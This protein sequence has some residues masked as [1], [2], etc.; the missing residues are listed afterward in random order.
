MMQ[1]RIIRG[2]GGFYYVRDAQGAEY[3][4]RARGR[5]RKEHK[6]PLVGDEVVFTPGQ[7]EEHG[8]L[9][10]ILPRRSECL[11]PPAAN[12]SLLLV[13]C[14]P[15][16]LPDLMLVDRLIIRAKRGN[17][18]A[19]LVINKCD[20]DPTLAETLS[21]QY[22]GAGVPI[23]PVSAR[24]A[25]GLD[26]LREIMRGEL[27]CVCG[28][29]AVGKSTL[30]NALCGL[31]LKTGEL[32]EKIRR[33]KNTTRHAELIERGGVAV[34]DTPGFSLLETDVFD[35]VE[36]KESYPEFAEYEG[37]CFFQP[38]YHATEPRCAVREAVTEGKI[39][40][41]RHE[42]YA[43]LLNEMKQRWRERYD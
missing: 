26:A 14:A 17:M 3:T 4:L 41:Q 5:F 21:R 27:C 20:L 40:A 1:G 22:A 6:T 29:S 42:R 18:K 11:R 38:C 10:E 2:I 28:Q 19:A 12:V 24:Q 9:D 16:P 30:L 43:A 32:S 8:W 33:G 37:Q 39:D 36:L 35:P 7:G 15:V 34:L 25:R 13:V 31:E 23:L